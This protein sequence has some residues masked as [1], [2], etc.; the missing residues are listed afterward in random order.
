MG[1][2]APT[3]RRS[4]CRLRRNSHR[5]SSELCGRQ[6]VRN[7]CH[8][9]CLAG[10]KD[11][12]QQKTLDRAVH[13]E[14]LDVAWS[15]HWAAVELDDDVARTQPRGLGRAALDDLHDLQA[16]APAELVGP[17]RRDRP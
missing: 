5:T 3:T 15:L 7:R 11:T 10:A 4:L 13:H 6:F 16:L 8:D 12:D 2:P 14:A 17:A 9:V 1:Y